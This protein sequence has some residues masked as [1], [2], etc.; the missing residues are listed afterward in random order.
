LRLVAPSRRARLAEY[1]EQMLSPAAPSGGPAPT[2][3]TGSN[4]LELTDPTLGAPTGKSDAE[5][6]PALMLGDPSNLR[7]RDPDRSLQLDLDD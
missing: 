4:G 7:L 5:G 6:G 1:L 3:G 2:A